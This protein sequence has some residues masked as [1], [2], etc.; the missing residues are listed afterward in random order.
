SMVHPRFSVQ[1]LDQYSDPFAVLGLSVLADEK[2]LLK[3][4]R[5]VA[6]R[7][8]PDSLLSASP[9][10]QDCATQLLARLVNPSHK[11]L[12]QKRGRA[13]CLA[14]L[15]FQVRQQMD[16]LAPT[17]EWGHNLL[18]TPILRVE[19]MYEQ[20]IAELGE[21]Q[22]N[23][24]EEFELI[25]PILSE[26]NLIYLRLKMKEP[27][28]REKRVG[29]ITPPSDQEIKIK[30]IPVDPA[31]KTLTYGQRYYRRAEEYLKK[32]NVTAAIQE[33]QDAIKLE[34][35]Q[36]HY[37]A[38]LAKA[39][40]MQKLPG[41]ARAYCRRALKLNCNN[42]LALQ[43]AKILKLDVSIFVDPPQT[44]SPKPNI[45]NIPGNYKPIYRYRYSNPPPEKTTGI[46][47]LFTWK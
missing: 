12:K 6:K 21:R 37:H 40:L 44:E 8:H 13:E 31:T 17:S 20:A 27:M 24:L 29:I 42:R 35:D 14:T 28:I 22:Y 3:R 46:F 9:E 47:N 26:L 41:A 23:P 18:K 39:Y 7:L 34:S 5:A 2:R 33:L 1:W 36:S 15:R 32:G 10:D 38:L 4:Y 19:A 43:C 11:K 45:S 30:T 25:T 16:T